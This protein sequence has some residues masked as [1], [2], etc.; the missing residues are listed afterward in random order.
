MGSAFEMPRKRTIFTNAPGM[1]CSGLSPIRR[2]A[3]RFGVRTSPPGPA[4]LLTNAW[5]LPNISVPGCRNSAPVPPTGRR[6]FEIS[7]RATGLMW[8][9]VAPG[10]GRSSQPRWAFRRTSSECCW[11][12]AADVLSPRRTT[13]SFLKKCSAPLAPAQTMSAS[14]FP[15]IATDSNRMS[16][17]GTTCVRF[18]WKI[19]SRSRFASPAEIPTSIASVPSF[20]SATPHTTDPPPACS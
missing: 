17:G 8:S 4:T 13:T 3:K 9:S 11:M 6:P 19:L 10:Q 7:T 20:R 2:I 15:S 18:S 12:V 16:T 14:W 1:K 5:V